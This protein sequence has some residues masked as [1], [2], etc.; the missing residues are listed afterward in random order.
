ME[1]TTTARLPLTHDEIGYLVATASR[2]PSLHN[3]QPWRFRVRE[4]VIELHADRGRNL[5]ITD[6]GGREMLISCGAALY[7]LW[8]GLRKLGYR[9]VVQ[10]LPDPVEPGLLARVQPGDRAPIT[11]HERDLLMAMPHRHTHRGPFAPGPVHAGLLARLCRDATA[12]GGA[13]VLID[14]PGRLRILFELATAASH[15]QPNRAARAEL[16]HWTRPPGSLARDGVPAWAWA[17]PAA[18][19]APDPAAGSPAP[20][21]ESPA[22]APGGLGRQDEGRQHDRLPQR[23]FGG[24]GLLPSGGSA[25]AATAVLTTPGDTPADAL[26]AG[27]ALHRV[28]LHAATRWVFAGLHTQPLELPAVRAEIRVRLA[29]DGV[30]QMLMQ[31]GRANTAAATARRPADEFIER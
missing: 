20:G 21:D 2:A 4:D 7:G 24:P 22:S 27:Q 18:E 30:P 26:R 23:D 8:L 17:A 16:R 6:P 9:P 3:T 25:P 15:E 19:A 11:V 31:F 1:M 14:Q 13:L 10:M 28:L 29:L 5:R 12:E